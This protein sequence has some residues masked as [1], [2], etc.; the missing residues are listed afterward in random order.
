MNVVRSI[1]GWIAP[2][3]ILGGAAAVF[4]AMGSQPPPTRSDGDAGAAV[5]VKTAVVTEGSGQ[6][7]I[8]LDGVVVPLKEVS[9]AAE[10]G[11]RV[12]L[13][14]EACEAGM[15]VTAGTLLLEIDPR[16]YELEVERLLREVAQAGIYIEEVGEELLQNQ[17]S[18]GLAQRQVELAQREVTRLETLKANR[19]VTESEHDR[20]L[21]DELTAI[22]TLTQLKGQQRVLEKRKNRLAEGRLLSETQLERVRI[23]LARTRVIAPFDGVI[24]NDPVEQDSYV[25]KGTPL[26]TLEDTSAAEIRTN[27]RMDEVARVWGSV[28]SAGSA[29]QQPSRGG[30]YDLPEVP[31]KVVFELGNRQFQWNGMLSRQEGGGLDART[32]TLPCRVLVPEPG[33]VTALDRYGQPLASLPPGSPTS[34]LRGMFVQV[35][36]LVEAPQQLVSVPAD[37]VRP[38]GDIWLIRNNELVIVRPTRVHATDDAVLY[39]AEDAGIVAGDKVIVSQLANPYAGMAVE[40]EPLPSLSNAETVRPAS[41][42]LAREEN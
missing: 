32:R 31:T 11:G 24:V 26:V 39:A 9:L 8:D 42:R 19:V 16:D 6:I 36:V 21:R 34:L 17:E 7:E 30:A 1:L 3:T 18:I 41:P 33:A 23:D 2:L 38:S 37:A 4:I 22:N 10:V 29:P 28:S 14:T 13:K 5:P 27:L 25:S 15:F 12:R 20:A 35:E 40:E